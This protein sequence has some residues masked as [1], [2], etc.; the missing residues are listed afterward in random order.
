MQIYKALIKQ[1]VTRRR[2]PQQN[3]CFFSNWRNFRK[4]CSESRRRRGRLLHRCGPAT[5]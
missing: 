1:A 5:V 4:V 3:R 2:C